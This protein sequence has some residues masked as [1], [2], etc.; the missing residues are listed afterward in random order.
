MKDS[1]SQAAKSP[2]P[3][4]SS[5]SPL[6]NLLKVSQSHEQAC[7]WPLGKQELGDVCIRE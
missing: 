6:V 1:K 4:S 5:Q 7:P 3:L 2:Q